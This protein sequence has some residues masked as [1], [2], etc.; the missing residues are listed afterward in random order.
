MPPSGSE[1][2]RP[3]LYQY[4]ARTGH[5]PPKHRPDVGR[6]GARAAVC[7][8]QLRQPGARQPVPA[9]GR[10][11]AGRL[12]DVDPA[13]GPRA[14][15]ARPPT[16]PLRRAR[17]VLAPCQTR[18]RRRCAPLRSDRRKGR[19]AD[20]CAGSGLYSGG[21]PAPMPHAFAAAC[22]APNPCRNFPAAVRP[23]SLGLS[24]PTPRARTTAPEPQHGPWPSRPRRYGTGTACP[25]SG[26]AYRSGSDQ[27]RRAALPT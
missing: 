24:R 14:L 11:L 18:Q 13:C 10:A 25:R 19:A 6:D 27:R 12:E 5:P 17:G 8:A 26:S 23:A 3:M 20:T 9:H 1:A 15:G 22:H 16:A 21:V 7:A 4:G 2:L